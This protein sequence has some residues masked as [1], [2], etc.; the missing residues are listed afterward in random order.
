M[1]KVM[2]TSVRTRKPE[3]PVN[4]IFLERWS[5][6]AMSG[7]DVQEIELMSLFEAAKWAPSSYNNQ[8]WRFIYAKRNT[9]AWDKFFGLLGEFNQAWCKNAAALVVVISKTTFDMNG[10]PARTHS[11]DTGAA[12]GY[13]ALQASLNGLVAHGMEGFDYERAKTELGIPDDYTVEAM[14][15]VGRPGKIED[16]RPALQAK[17]KPSDRK[18][19]EEIVFE[20]SFK[21]PK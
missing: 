5:P 21:G 19:L 9:A 17:E 1:A 13:F 7:E 20:G 12:W 3:Y 8:S 14:A 15:A 10:K 4:H 11:Y 6:R 18:K 2:E 16:L